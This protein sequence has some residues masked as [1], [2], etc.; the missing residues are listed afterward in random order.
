M[1]IIVSGG[2]TGGHIYPAL[3]LIDAIKNKKPDA[4]FLYVG[5][6]KGLEADIVPKAGINFTALKLEGGLERRFTLENISRAANAVWSIKHA[7][8]IVKNF[9]PSAV[10]GTG[11]YVCGPILLAAS[12]MKVPT[13]IQEQNAVAG[14]T[15]KILSKF[16]NKIAVGTRDAL[17]N[18]PPDKTVYT[19]NPIRKEVLAAKKADG[20]RK[21]NFT[22]DKPIVLIS[23][24]SRGARS[25]NNAM[26]DVLKSAAQKNSAQ[27]LHVTGKGEF[28]SVMKK[29]SDAG[30]NVDEFKNIKVMP[31]LYNM[32]TAMAMADLAIFRAGATGLAELTARGIPAI[33]IPY[34]YAAENHQEFN[35]RSLVEAGAA[36]MILNKD[37]TAEI[38]S[39]T[40]NELL[41]APEKLKSMAAASLS[42][43]KP[44]AADEIADLI[45]KLI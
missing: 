26:I 20:L 40:L 27:F 7:S 18:F 34:P 39:A 43:G 6:E 35:A 3:T 24:G 25:I 13:L 29:L 5:T 17:K 32:P 45:L 21:F 30:L 12:L 38:L 31:Y 10:V 28:D 14:V 2:G 16:V 22:D 36:R 8:D 37:L 44:N 9:K 42:L 11:G 19:G 33:L 1:K 23:G 15:N 4:E 41:S